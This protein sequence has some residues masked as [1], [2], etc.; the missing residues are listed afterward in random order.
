MA[1]KADSRKHQKSELK[2]LLDKIIGEAERQN[3]L[4]EGSRQLLYRTLAEA[5]EWWLDAVKIDGFLDEL[6]SEYSLRTKGQEENFTRLIR[7]VWQLDWNGRKAPA[8]Q[9]WSKA[10][11][12]IDQEYNADKKRFAKNTATAIVQLINAR[13]GLRGLIG[14]KRD[15]QDSDAVVFISKDKKRSNAPI[16]ELNE[17]KLFAKH[18]QLGKQ[19]FD[20]AKAILTLQDVQQSFATRD[21]GY[22]VALIRKNKNSSYKILSISNEKELVESAIVA[23]YKRSSGDAPLL[24]RTLSEVIE[25]QSLPSALEAYRTV[26][27]ERGKFQAADG[28]NMRQIK[29]ILL[30]PKSKTILLSESRTACSVVTIAKPK[31]FPRGIVRSLYL[32]TEN[33]KFIEQE[34]LQKSN[35]CFHTT[36][37]ESIE[38]IKDEEITA[39]HRIRVKNNVTNRIKNLFFYSLSDELGEQGSQ[40]YFYDQKRKFNWIATASLDWFKH[41]EVEFVS[42]WLP[43]FGKRINRQE[44]KLI[45][46]A[47]NK[48]QFVIS[49]SGTRDKMSKNLVLHEIPSISASSQPLRL[50]FQSKDIIPILHSI[51]KQDVIGKISMAAND[52][53]L[54]IKYATEI[55]SYLIAIPTAN[56]RARRNQSAFEF[57]GASNGN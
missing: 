38:K 48:K 28:K 29:R 55:S 35:L 16:D 8:L 39:T 23:T 5:Y 46:I 27:A 45:R 10:L 1:T 34:I 41:V 20:S 57:F 44:N 22:A 4:H 13:G 17:A 18:L 7:L 47:S 33:H 50:L 31:I 30:L 2:K 43:E 19:S 3:E 15:S 32:R 24:L 36:L 42:Q 49:F 12:K 11:R 21:N 53:V 54:V 52:D 56:F 26:L 37:S 40:A 25:T 14:E 51:S 6:Y 9:V